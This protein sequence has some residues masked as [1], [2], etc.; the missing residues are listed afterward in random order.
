MQRKLLIKT[1]GFVT[2]LGI[3]TKCHWVRVTEIA[4][5]S[6]RH[7]RLDS[8]RPSLVWGEISLP[9]HRIT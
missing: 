2:K 7:L 3:F 9:K 4:H 6:V 8:V 5:E 1:Y